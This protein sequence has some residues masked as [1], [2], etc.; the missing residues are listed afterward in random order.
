MTELNYK[1]DVK[2][3]I[4]SHKNSIK[5]M[6]EERQSLLFMEDMNTACTFFS[7]TWK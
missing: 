3:G 5:A 6:G 4:S 7:L 1:W 2:M